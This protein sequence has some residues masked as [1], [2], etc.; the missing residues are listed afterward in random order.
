MARALILGGTGAIGRATAD[1]LNAAGW[2]VTITG[3]NP[4][5]MPSSLTARGVGFIRSDRQDHAGPLD[6]LGPAPDLLVDLVCYTA[7]DVRAILPFA[8]AAGS[9]VLMSSKAVYVD[10]EGRSLN[11][12]IEPVFDGPITEAQPTL[13]PRSDIHYD[14]REGYGA[15]KVAAEQEYLGSGIPVTVLRPSKVHGPG[16]RRAREWMFVRRVLD[17]RPAVFLSDRGTGI[18]HTSAAA[19]VAAL[20]E[21]VATAP[22]ARVLNSADPDAPTVLEITRAIASHLSHDWEEILVDGDA[23]GTNPW[24]RDHPIVLDM[25]AALALG[26]QPTGDYPT[27]VAATVDWLV[28]AAN[29]GEDAALLPTAT[30]PFFVQL[31]SYDAEDAYLAAR[32]P[33]D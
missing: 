15:N 22:S 5:A 19:N 23:L 21:V 26:Y 2:T 30:D 3:R 20:I 1:R 13:A 11:A 7:A 32:E 27:T 6:Q 29:G 4:A 8:R 17:R 25:Q 12:D 16:A 9:T 24:Q 31:L 33:D 14:T 18:D 10:D 28:S